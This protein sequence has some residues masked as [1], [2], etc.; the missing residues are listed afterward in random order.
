MA[1]VAGEWG[2]GGG[3]GEPV[4][5]SGHPGHPG[6]RCQGNGAPS[7]RGMGEEQ[8]AGWQRLQEL[9]EVNILEFSVHRDS[10]FPSPFSCSRGL[11]ANLFSFGR[12]PPIREGGD[13]RQ[14]LVLQWGIS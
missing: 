1:C 7:W 5:Q 2:A 3:G 6:E 14:D 11:R 10:S 4:L 9:S 8:G 13:G 12:D